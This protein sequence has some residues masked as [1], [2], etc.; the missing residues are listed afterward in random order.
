MVFR[1]RSQ[2]LVDLPQEILEVVYGGVLDEDG[3]AILVKVAGGVGNGS[4]GILLWREGGV[5]LK[6]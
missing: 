1:L 6:S 3:K 2:N 4:H 5:E